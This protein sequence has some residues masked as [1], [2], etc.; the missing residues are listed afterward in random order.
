MIYYIGNP[1]P[2]NIIYI[3]TTDAIKILL[4][5]ATRF[6]CPNPNIM[7]KYSINPIITECNTIVKPLSILY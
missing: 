1:C 2:N 5:S 4:F 6:G 7:I 3:K